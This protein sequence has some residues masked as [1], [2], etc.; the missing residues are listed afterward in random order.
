MSLF[1]TLIPGVAASEGPL[2]FQA[3]ITGSLLH[4][5]LAGSLH[6][7]PGSLTIRPSGAPLTIEP[8][9][10]RLQGDRLI[11]PHLVFHSGDGT[12]EITGGANLVNLKFQ[13]VQLVLKATNLLI[14]QREGSRAVAN[15]QISLKGSWPVLSGRRPPY[16]Q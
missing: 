3:Q 14:I 12:G 16:G 11:L 4:P 6:Y 8:G 9:E 1:S 7:G 13:D 10:L 2:N 15:G 5:L